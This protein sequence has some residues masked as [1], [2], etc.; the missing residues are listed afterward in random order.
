[1]KTITYLTG[2]MIGLTL[3]CGCQKD[4]LD[5]D[6]VIYGSVGPPGL[7]IHFVDSEGNNL[8]DV[9][10]RDFLGVAAG[11]TFSYMGT[12]YSFSLYIKG[13]GMDETVDYGV[14]TILTYLQDGTPAW[15]A[16]AGPMISHPSG[17]LDNWYYGDTTFM[18]IGLYPLLHLVNNRDITTPYYVT[19]EFACPYLFGNDEV[20]I[21]QATCSR[22]DGGR[23]YVSELLWNGQK[24]AALSS[25]YSDSFYQ[26]VVK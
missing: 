23:Y 11:S 8:L 26:V 16:N 19:I 20:Q 2:I 21:F 17:E 25:R 10:P 5:S 15:D 3:F 1:M 12:P 24:Q 18:S 6:D 13:E 14:K 22:K 9:I 4:A 7:R